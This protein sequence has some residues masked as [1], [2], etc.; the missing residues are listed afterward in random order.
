MINTIIFDFGDVFINLDKSATEKRLTQ[1][2]LNNQLA[3]HQKKI[4]QQ[5][6]VGNMTTTEFIKNYQKLL[7]NTSE[8]E[9]K[10]A[11]NAILSDFPLHRLEFIEKLADEKK[12][13]L[14]LLSNTNELHIDWIKQHVAFYSKFKSCFDSFYL[15]HEIN[16]RKP[17]SNIFEFVLKQHQLIP[18][19]TLFIDDTK[20]NT[21]TASSL[22][23]HTW[24]NDPKTDDITE[25][26]ITKSDLF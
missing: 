10:N 13:K 2:G 4:D 16:L 21:D 25:L 24:N 26:F 18:S 6:E 22:G 20:E 11:W 7:P 8:K 23:I 5:Y 17:D 3:N 19:E 14:I 9:I 15:S 12:Y 1:L